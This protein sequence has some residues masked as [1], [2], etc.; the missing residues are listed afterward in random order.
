MNLREGGRLM[1]DLAQRTASRGRT[2]EATG[3]NGAIAMFKLE[4]GLLLNLYPRTGL[5]RD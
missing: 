5:A 4:G 3:A 2:D 1:R